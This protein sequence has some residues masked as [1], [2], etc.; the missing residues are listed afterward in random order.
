LYFLFRLHDSFNR[1]KNFNATYAD[2]RDVR[3]DD[4][5]GRVRERFPS[6]VPIDEEQGGGVPGDHEEFH[7][8]GAVLPPP[9]GVCDE[10]RSAG[11]QE[12]GDLA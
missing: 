6:V 1:R 9:A 7:D 10:P 5:L 3:D 12:G 2:I 11:C 8:V 4:F